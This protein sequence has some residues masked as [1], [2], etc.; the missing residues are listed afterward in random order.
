MINKLSNPKR[1]QVADALAKAWSEDLGT[2]F[3]TLPDHTQFG[4]II[5]K[6]FSVKGTVQTLKTRYN[7]ELASHIANLVRRRINNSY[8]TEVRE[9]GL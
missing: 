8:S 9:V 2:H 4:I 3:S 7:D 6:P 5:N 1:Y